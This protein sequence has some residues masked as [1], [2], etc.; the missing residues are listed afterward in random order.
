MSNKDFNMRA[1]IDIINESNEI[2][3]GWASGLAGAAKAVGNDIATGIKKLGDKVGGTKLGQKVGE[4][5][6]AYNYNKYSADDIA[7]YDALV[8]KH[9]LDTDE[10]DSLPRLSRDPKNLERYR[11]GKQSDMTNS[12]EYSTMG[13]LDDAYRIQNNIPEKDVKF[14]ADIERSGAGWNLPGEDS[15]LDV[16]SR[17]SKRAARMREYGPSR[18]RGRKLSLADIERNSGRV[19]YND[20][21]HRYSEAEFDEWDWN[22]IPK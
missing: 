7:R 11:K 9:A 8:K 3:E 1:Y 21:N 10:I 20:P 22:E 17:S 16:S 19:K 2:E 12:D 15:L 4:Y 6:D 18:R 14:M 13:D 5:K